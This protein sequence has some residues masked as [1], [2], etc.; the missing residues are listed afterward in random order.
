MTFIDFGPQCSEGPIRDGPCQTCISKGIH[1]DC[2]RVPVGEDEVGHHSTSPPALSS[3]RNPAYNP[4][5][6]A[7]SPL[8]TN[9]STY[10]PSA[11]SPTSPSTHHAM[12]H[13]SYA[14]DGDPSTAYPVPI[15]S[16][17]ST[18]ASL[19]PA[20]SSAPSSM[21]ATASSYP[22]AYSSPHPNPSHYIPAGDVGN[23]HH[24]SGPSY[25]PSHGHDGDAGSTWP[26]QQWP[27][28]SQSQRPSGVV[29][30]QTSGDLYAMSQSPGQYS[31]PQP[32][33]M[34]DY[35]QSYGNRP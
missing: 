21:A 20:Y 13:R 18:L 33:G 26:A 2:V 10:G 3:P 16:S 15:Q 25:A 12:S 31:P 5:A 23:V 4:Q 11:F 34:Q 14:S 30:P 17:S 29:G 8:Y 1:T 6:T 22:A 27:H 28:P 19:Y 35:S 32:Y 24:F 7:E 9:H